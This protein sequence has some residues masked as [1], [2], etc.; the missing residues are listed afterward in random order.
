MLSL[1]CKAAIKA[2]VHLA[3][4]MEMDEKFS[5]KEI[6]ENIDENEHTVGKL[7][8]KLVKDNIINS[9]KG[10]NGGFFITEQQSKNNILQIVN[11]IDGKEVFKSCGL[12]L[13]KCSESHP[14]PIH[15]E[16]KDVRDLFQNLCINTKIHDLCKEVTEGH[17]FLSRK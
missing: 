7:L 16:Y 8:Q 14:C 3:S 17:A 15:N 1:T 13:N 12:G 11:C 4:K 6:A 9:S 5:I 2:T 10:P